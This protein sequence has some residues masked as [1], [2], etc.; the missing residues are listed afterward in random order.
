MVKVKNMKCP[1][2]GYPISESDLYIHP[3]KSR[4]DALEVVLKL[5]AEL[6]RQIREDALKLKAGLGSQ[7]AWT[8]VIMDHTY[9]SFDAD[10]VYEG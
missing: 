4:E 6:E 9:T 5:K 8:E 7:G 10:A 2:C 3:S 1:Q